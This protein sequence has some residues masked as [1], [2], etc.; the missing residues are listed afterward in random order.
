MYR[1]SLI[2]FYYKPT[3]AQLISQPDTSST[4][5]ATDQR[6]NNIYKRLYMQPQTHTDYTKA[7][8]FCKFWRSKVLRISATR[9]QQFSSWRIHSNKGWRVKFFFNHPVE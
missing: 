7:L 9:E 6:S 3:N 8:D 2:I 4:Q 1:A 5:H